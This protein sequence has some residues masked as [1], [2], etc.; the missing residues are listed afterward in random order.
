MHRAYEMKVA[1]LILLGTVAAPKTASAQADVAV[2]VDAS[3]A[4]VA[5]AMMRTARA[6]FKNLKQ[7]VADDAKVSAAAQFAKLDAQSTDAQ[8]RRLRSTLVVSKLVVLSAVGSKQNMALGL[9]AFSDSPLRVEFAKATSKTLVAKTKTLLHRLFDPSRRQTEAA[10]PK[11]V[12][13]P[14]KSAET[15][16][17]NLQLNIRRL[18]RLEAE[19]AEVMNSSGP[20]TAQVI[21]FTAFG[22]GT[23]AAIVGGVLY[24]NDKQCDTGAFIGGNCDAFSGMVIGGSVVGVTGLITAIVSVVNANANDSRAETLQAEIDALKTEV[25]R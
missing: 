12:A 2:I 14:S 13:S 7:T 24:A 4:Q 22:L 1:L 8:Y 9:R 20:Q 11:A 23:V 15:V 17:T 3:S 21:G 18:D 5:N 16:D 25:A 6:Y 10:L 19:Y